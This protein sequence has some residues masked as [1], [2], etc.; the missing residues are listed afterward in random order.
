MR[1]WLLGIAAGLGAAAGAGYGIYSGER[2]AAYSF[3]GAVLLPIGIL[4]I[5]LN[6]WALRM[7]IPWGSHFG[8]TEPMLVVLLD[9]FIIVVAIPAYQDF[10]V[11]S[12]VQETLALAAP[13]IRAI[14]TQFELRKEFPQG[15]DPARTIPLTTGEKAS[16]VRY[17]AKSGIVTVVLA[18]SPVEGKSLVFVPKGDIASKPVWMCSSPDIRKIHLPDGCR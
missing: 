12:K 6:V 8:K 13:L 17:D 4:L 18:F 16:V 3:A 2:I 1:L 9:G 10:L 15:I 7:L 5:W 11:R 14:E